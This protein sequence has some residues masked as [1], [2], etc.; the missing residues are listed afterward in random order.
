MLLS[1]MCSL[2]IM[3]QGAGVV[4]LENQIVYNR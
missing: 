3:D 4:G 1:I 2:G